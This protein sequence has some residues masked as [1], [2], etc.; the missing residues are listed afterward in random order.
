MQV[1]GWMGR[2]QG[3]E[4]GSQALEC[5]HAFPPPCL[6]R[7]I[8]QRLRVSKYLQLKI[9]KEFTGIF[10]NPFGEGLQG[11]VMFGLEWLGFKYQDP[12]KLA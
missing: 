12:L 2:S 10:T 7:Q 9:L 1:A 11:D 8:R 6:R 5:H 4:P 3:W